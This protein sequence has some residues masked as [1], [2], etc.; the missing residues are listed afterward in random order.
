MY[1]LVNTSVPNGLIA[2]THG[3]ATV[4]MTKG[5]PDAI[6]VRVEG[7]C[8]YPHRTSAHD[9]S[10]YSENPVNWFHLTVSGDGHVVG[11]TAP[12][13]FDYTGRTNRL[14]R[15]LFFAARE[16][17]A[18]GGMA[19]LKAV[20][21]R[22]CE[23]WRG[24]P[25]YVTDDKAL[26]NCLRQ[27][28]RPRGADP[29]HWRTLLGPQ[30][31]EY[32]RRF[33]TLLRQNLRTGK[34]L[35]F[36]AAKTDVDG[37]RLLGLF[38]DLINLLPDDLAA[39]VTFS[40]FADCV[41]N[42]CVCHLR[43]IYDT[44]RAF[45]VASTLQ[46]WV[47]CE[48]GIVQNVELLPQENSVGVTDSL[49][50][51]EA[52]PTVSSVGNMADRRGSG[53]TAATQSGQATPGSVHDRTFVPTRKKILVA[54][55][56]LL[57]GICVGSV[58]F[59]NQRKKTERLERENQA[60]EKW[61]ASKTNLVE[62][63]REKVAGCD[64]LE[65]LEELRQAIK[66][67]KEGLKQSLEEEGCRGHENLLSEVQYRY[68]SLLDCDLAEKEKSIAEQMRA[69]KW[70]ACATNR[71]EDFRT[72]IENCSSTN[73]LEDLRV[74]I[75]NARSR[76]EESFEMADCRGHKELLSE[77][78]DRY[79]S[80][81]DKDL[82][83][84]KK[85]LKNDAAQL[86]K[87]EAERE[88]QKEAKSGPAEKERKRRE[89]IE[90]P[91]GSLQLTEILSASQSWEEKLKDEE[92]RTLTNRQS[93]VF[94]FLCN[95]VCTN[96]VAQFKEKEKKDPMTGK[97]T[98]SWSVDGTTDAQTCPWF[99]VSIPSL[100]RVYWQWK[101][102][103]KGLKL[104]EKTDSVDLSNIVF[105]GT[106]EAFRVYGKHCPPIVYVVSW[107][108][109]MEPSRLYTTGSNVSIDHLKPSQKSQSGYEDEIEHLE[110]LANK[111]EMLSNREHCK[112][113]ADDW[114]K[115]MKDTLTEY[116][117]IKKRKVNGDKEK[118][119][120]TEE[121]ENL[122]VSAY[123]L[124]QK[125]SKWPIGWKMKTKGKDA[126]NFKK[127]KEKDCY[128]A[129]RAYTD[130]CTDD[131]NKC[132]KEIKVIEDRIKKSSKDSQDW[133]AAAR[134]WAYSVDVLRG[135]LPEEVKKKLAQ[136]ELK[137]WKDERKIDKII[138]PTGVGGN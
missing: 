115:Q 17:P 26:A 36:K 34:S 118:E 12:A 64:S 110:E 55:V 74:E 16:M 99:V 113:N 6:R 72:R 79:A 91:L 108:T 126:V 117:N 134:E 14:S 138:P 82:A 124:F 121:L 78:R 135:E 61:Y 88:Q 49:L 76:L 21:D 105:G 15:T 25:R 50:S 107:G 120:K 47:D 22:F 136:D 111:K 20:G 67:A 96:V 86:A 137:K 101:T 35:F 11:R 109:G 59:V 27:I 104:F 63:F 30:G 130:G 114:Y 127:I 89:A 10:Y 83:E 129:L 5:M 103:I 128:N 84:K 65:N 66:K 57:I 37:T 13:E 29:S 132:T 58:F 56:C 71:V 46:P 2:G 8:A 116:E 119:K 81:L 40:T 60:C 18:A 41:P 9:A 62:E 69:R 90:R 32:A 53:R 131:I 93:I 52:M 54:A 133:N 75:T 51:R 94:H 28:A 87:A 38:D 7:L 45:E 70:Y 24:E 85:S 23:G 43:G 4:A 106:N 68:A 100:A 123:D 48:R 73:K 102:P 77:V 39:Q 125:F 80:L 92:K 44:D 19:V 112:S 97:R 3:F 122:A 1:E 42:G 98:R 31:S 95:G 33:A